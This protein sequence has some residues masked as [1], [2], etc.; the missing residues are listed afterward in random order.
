MAVM[1][2]LVVRF[3]GFSVPVL[4]ALVKLSHCLPAEEFDMFTMCVS[5]QVLSNYTGI[6]V[7]L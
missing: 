6:S 5:V 1:S 3:L 4:R 7:C 2:F